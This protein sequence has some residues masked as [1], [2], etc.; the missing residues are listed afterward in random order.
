[1]KSA[2]TAFFLLLS[3]SS[4]AA[5]GIIGQ[6]VA[7]LPVVQQ[8]QI[9]TD[10]NEGAFQVEMPQKWK[11]S[12]GLARRNALQYRGWSTAISPDGATILAI[13]DP[14]EP[15][16][17]APSPTLAAAGFRLGSVYNGG[18]GTTYIVAPYESGVQFTISWGQRKLRDL[19]TFAKVTSSRARPEIS[20]QINAF[21]RALGISHD[22]GE[23]TFTC[24]KNGLQMTAYVLASTTLIRGGGQGGIWY[25]DT[26]E[27][28]LA[29][30][31]VAGPAAGLLAHMVKS[32][33]ANPTWMARQS[34]T[35]ADVSRIVT[36]SNAAISD[37]IMHG[38]EE[39]GAIQDRVM[40]EGSRTRLGIDVYA[41]PATGTQ[42][43]VGN[44]YSYYWANAGGTVIGTDTATPP[45]L[46]FSRLTRV[47][48]Q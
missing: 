35:S 45:G 34:Q 46:N 39:R 26:I 44:S 24:L 38:W 17:V 22:Y 4:A 12:G 1:M 27:S 30:T 13:N 6:P 14:A 3:V 31:A 2:S 28:F 42:Y 48:P 10:P 9:F 8:W 41:D 18:G 33:R 43:T 25:A 40:E 47:P 29:P 11:V 19:C 23:S 36:Q 16:Y 5:Q 15:S 21:S 20:Q 32:V 7:A 37:S